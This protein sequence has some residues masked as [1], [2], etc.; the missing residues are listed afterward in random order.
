[1]AGAN[2]DADHQLA[3]AEPEPRAGSD[4]L[5]T[6]LEDGR[7]FAFFQ[8]VR[9]LHDLHP[10]RPQ[11][12]RQG[13]AG[14]EPVRLVGWLSLAFPPGDVMSVERWEPP[15]PTLDEE[16]EP[17]RPIEVPPFR[18]ESPL[19]GLYG[20][21]SPLPTCYTEVLLDQ[22]QETERRFYDLFQHRLLSLLW[23]VWA[24]YRWDVGFRRDASDF[25]SD[26]LTRFVGVGPDALP[27]GH[28]SSRLNLLALGGLLTFEPRGAAGM[29]LA[30]RRAFPS[31]EVDVE[32][33]ATRWARLPEE[34]LS[35]LG[36]KRC[37]LG[38]NA[39]LGQ[40][41]LDR[42]GTFRVVV[43]CPDTATYISFLEDEGPLATLRELVDLFN[44]DLLDCELELRLAITARHE[45]RLGARDLRLGWSSWI[46][47]PAPENRWIRRIFIGAFHG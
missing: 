6:L 32:P 2:R 9:L 21:S 8:A 29:E 7:R 16:D 5:A 25:F 18:L 22:E 3:L 27:A 39:V 30:L 24:R 1:M 20:S 15:P 45:S 40:K 28:R 38:E 11:V 44:P 31:C 41:L 13:P 35:R 12:G 43:R 34:D 10:D 4:L 42:A 14:R 33:F 17:G 47:Q 26:R 19:L 36:N 23:R 46:G 37:V